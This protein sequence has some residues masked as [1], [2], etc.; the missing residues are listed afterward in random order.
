MLGIRKA[1]EF[2]SAFRFSGLHRRA[3]LDLGAGVARMVA[4]NGTRNIKELIEKWTERRSEVREAE[5]FGAREGA[6]LVDE[7]MADLKALDAAAEVG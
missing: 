6:G 5:F 3:A 7:F 1:G 4:M 2:S